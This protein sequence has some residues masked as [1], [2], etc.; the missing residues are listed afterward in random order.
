MAQ[1]DNP[2]LDFASLRSR[3]L[4][5][6]QRLAGSSWT[7]HNTHDPGITLLETLC[8]ALT[9]LGFRTDFPVQDL[10]AGDGQTG[11]GLSGLFTPAQVL[12]S[13]PVTL[14]DLRKLVV[15]IPGVRNAWVERV[16]EPL[17]QHDGAQGVLAALPWPDANNAGSPGSG[18]SASSASGGGAA[19]PANSS[20]NMTALRPRGLIRV[21]IEKSGLGEDVDGATL[22]RRAAQRLQHWRG[23]GEDIDSITVQDTQP[24]ALDGAIEIAP[25]TDEA[26]LLASL[27]QAL[28]NHLSPAVPFR[29]LRD[30]LGRGWR[31]DQIF[32]GPLLASG[33]LDPAEWAAVQRRSSVRLSDLIQVLMAV[34]GVLA[35]KSLGFLRD[36]RVSRDWLLAIDAQRSASFDAAGSDL[37]LERRG[38]RIDNAATRASARRLFEARVRQALPADLAGDWRGDWRADAPADL[39]AGPAAGL[40]QADRDIAPPAGRDRQVDR[41]SVV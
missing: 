21:R 17:G 23:L 7:D 12:P 9:D 10:L 16:D 34:P 31:V 24:V 32:D 13:A 11:A 36:G 37:R 29:T 2:M 14:S 18:S 41:K 5:L 25:G 40:A 20:P 33:F 28:A 1:P 30:L 26:S 35:V 4:G 27:Y 19:P 22:V 3:G 15:D 39:P 38:L 8:Y 6:L